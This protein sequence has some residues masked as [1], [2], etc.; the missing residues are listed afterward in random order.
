MIQRFP[1]S[2]HLLLFREN[3]ILLMQRCNT[4]FEDGSYSLPAGKLEQEECVISAMCREAQEEL[5]IMIAE[6]NMQTVQVMN[7]MGNDGNRID[8]F[9][10][11][12]TWA[13]EIVNNEPAKCSNIQWFPLY[14]LPDNIIPYIKAAIS[15]YTQGQRFTTYGW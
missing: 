10:T 7:R 11:A 6:E 4:G 9:F 14:A 8:Y 5:G 1:V 3:K 2:V 12:Q 13:G 15:F